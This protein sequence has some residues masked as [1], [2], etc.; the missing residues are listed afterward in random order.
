MVVLIVLLSSSFNSWT[1]AFYFVSFLFPIVVGT[2][3]F[4]NQILVPR[5]LM[6]DQ[7][8]KFGLYTF[9][10]VVVSVYL[11]LLVMLVAF[12]ILADYQFAN[13]GELA[14]DI[15][16]LILILYLVVLGYGY[17]LSIQRLRDR[18]SQINAFNNAQTENN[19]VLTVLV[20]RKKVPIGIDQILF[21]E[22]LSDYVK[23]ITKEGE[24]IVRERISKLEEELGDQFLRI[25]RS[26][27]INKAHIKSYNKEEI[28]V[29]ERSVPIGRKFK[30]QVAETL[31]Q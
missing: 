13:M 11:E 21:I 8:W 25:H 5:Y 6:T 28:E 7:K 20:Q 19:P 1:L 26:F 9:Y 30:A 17:M 2:S 29:G 12:V 23:I 31:D 22:S 4:F 3:I 18:E 16:W 10:M 14:G 27:L 15:R 24:L